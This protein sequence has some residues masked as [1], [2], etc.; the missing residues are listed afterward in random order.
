MT[1][2][3]ITAGP[4]TVETVD[5]WVDP[6]CPWAWATARWLLEVERERGIEVRFHVMS[7]AVLNAGRDVDGIY[8][9]LLTEG[10]GP[11]RVCI[12]AQRAC[13]PQA[14]R[15]L[16]LAM[17]R[18]IHHEGAGRQRPM[19]LRALE[20]AGL[21]TALADAA[22]VTEHDA[23]LRDSH[24]AGMA[25]V[26]DEVGTPVVHVPVG[27]GTTVA[28]F[29]PVIERVPTGPDAGRLWD[30]VVAVARWPGFTELK[31]S[32]TGLPALD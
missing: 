5:L 29:G 3:T 24:H 8:R 30:G 7:L 25:P 13:G 23:T 18:L 21:P 26:G 17:G 10:W 1:S 19:L 11:V 14:L 4:Q 12:A 2:P 32:R 9:I 20:Q 28:F 22:T 31:R 6:V 16:Y 15:P 27:D